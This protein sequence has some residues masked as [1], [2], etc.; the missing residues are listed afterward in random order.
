MSGLTSTLRW[1]TAAVML[2]AGLVALEWLRR[3]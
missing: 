1:V 2:I 3:I